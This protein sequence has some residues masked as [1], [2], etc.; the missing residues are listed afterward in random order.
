M[1][2]YDWQQPLSQRLSAILEASKTAVVAL[3]TGSGKSYIVADAVSRVQSPV[4]TICPKSVRSM[5]T[6]LLQDSGAQA[7]DVTNWEK[8]KT[9]KTVCW[10][11]DKGWQLPAGSIVVLDEAHKQCS[12]EDSKSGELMARL[13]CYP[14]KIV[15]VSATMAA[16]PLQMRH[17][18][19]L[20][21]L[22]K[23]NKFDYHRWLKSQDCWYDSGSRHWYPPGGNKGLEVM[24]GIRALI[25][26]RMLA[27][28][29]SEIPNFPETLIQCKLYDLDDRATEEINAAYAEMS[30]R[31]KKPG[32]SPLAE[33]NKARERT[34]MLKTGLLAELI[35]DGVEAGNSAATFLNYREPLFRL[36]ELLKS[37]GLNNISMVYGGQDTG[38]STKNRDKEILAFRN[39]TNPV[40]LAMAQAGGIAISLHPLASTGRPRVSLINPSYSASDV[41][42]CLGRVHRMSGSPSVQTFVLVANSV[43]ERVY[44]AV[45][46]KLKNI[47]TFNEGLTDEDL[48]I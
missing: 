19:Y 34:E 21:G 41:R 31:M 3:P 24:S 5:W 1:Q 16:S 44:K 11:K 4:L 38:D 42:Q 8:L 23:W 26:D 27:M 18:G 22:H 43:E 28:K 13:N 17:S 14:V 32:A 25:S 39:D 35:A 33:R 47:D 29:L 48:E 30:E 2:L 9:G 7:L 10:D 45:S 12:G 20:L 36:Q 46:A 40:C 6:A 15:M 37:K